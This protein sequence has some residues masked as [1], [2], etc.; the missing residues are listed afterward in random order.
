MT[1][2]RIEPEGLNR[3]LTDSNTAIQAVGTALEASIETV[4]TVQAA[5]GYDS[6]VASAHA[7]FM[8]ELFDGTVKTMFTKYSTALEGTANAANAY[9][10]GDEQI[11]GTIAT[12]I[13]SS[14]FGGALFAPPAGAA[15]EGDEG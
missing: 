6:I 9:L 8:Q 1:G 3:I 15:S 5:G 4:G 13:G 2:W 14:D 10:A 7:G 11:A 12:G